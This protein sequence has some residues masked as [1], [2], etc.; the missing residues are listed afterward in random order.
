[1]QQRSTQLDDRVATFDL[2][3]SEAIASG[4]SVPLSALRA[5]MESLARGLDAGDARGTLLH[6]ALDE[7]VRMGRNVQALLDITLP[8]PLRP[9]H[10]TLEEIAQGALQ[11]IGAERATRVLLAVEDGRERLFVD[12]PLLSGAL[13]HLIEAGLC[14]TSH[15]VLASARCSSGGCVFSVLYDARPLPLPDAGTP[16]A[17]VRSPARLGL[18]FARRQLRRMGGDL[19][20]ERTANGQVM[21]LARL[22]CA[23][24]QEAA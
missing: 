5:S 7:I 9:L 18:E 21:W 17:A 6:S 15:P 4:I 10:C 24:A 2:D 16:P 20:L 12:G 1:M 11:A 22:P 23:D 8:P 13:S 19:G 3:L 14:E